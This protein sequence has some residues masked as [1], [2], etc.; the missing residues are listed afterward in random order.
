M[1]RAA[2]A[3]ECF[4][5]FVGYNEEFGFPPKNHGSYG[6]VPRQWNW[7]LNAHLTCAF[8]NEGNEL[9]QGKG[10]HRKTNWEVLA[11]VQANNG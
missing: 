11:E 2:T 8:K 9:K 5:C 10:N 1:V 6:R 7:H 3:H 4:A